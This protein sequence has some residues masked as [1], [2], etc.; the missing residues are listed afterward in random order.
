[1]RSVWLISYDISDPGRLRRVHRLLRGF[2]DWMQYSVFRCEL[3]E[4]ERVKVQALL[5]TEIN[6]EQDQV[7][8]A[9][10]GPADGTG[11]RSLASMGRPLLPRVRTVVL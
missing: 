1:M 2:G 9:Y 11:A 3:G 10:L 7:L 4:R 8:F 5:E 6:H